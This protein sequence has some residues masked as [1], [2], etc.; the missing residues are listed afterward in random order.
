MQAQI[1]LEGHA[2]SILQK[3]LEIHIAYLGSGFSI[4]QELFF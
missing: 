4:K 1:V 3:L 2:M